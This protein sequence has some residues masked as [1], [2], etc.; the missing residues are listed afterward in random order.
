VDA[1]YPELSR[2]LQEEGPV[3]VYFRLEQ[4]EGAATAIRVGQSSLSAQLDEAAMLYIANQTFRVAC[5]K[6]E[7]R[8]RVRFRLQDEVKSP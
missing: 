2:R 3:A 6:H 5:P 8:L 4:E 7:F 1:F